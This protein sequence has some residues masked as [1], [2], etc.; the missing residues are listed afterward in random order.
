MAKL[1]LCLVLLAVLALTSGCTTVEKTLGH[2]D[3]ATATVNEVRSIGRKAQSVT[4][5]VK[6]VMK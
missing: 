5:D 6:K 4:S 1:C 3:S 2:Y